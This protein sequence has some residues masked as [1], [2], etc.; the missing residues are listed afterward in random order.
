MPGHGF[1]PE[2]ARIAEAIRARIIDGTCPPGS[3]LVEG[4]IAEELGMS[5]LPDPATGR[6]P[7]RQVLLSMNA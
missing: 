6:L 7:A 2:P 4:G 1:E 3:R 5:R